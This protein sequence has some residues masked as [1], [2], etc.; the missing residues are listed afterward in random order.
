MNDYKKLQIWQD[1]MELY[2]TV[3]PIFHALRNQRFYRLLDQLEGS[4]GSVADNIAEGQGRNGN[5]E[6]LHFLGIAKGSLQE[7]DS[8]LHRVK[9]LKICDEPTLTEALNKTD[10]LQARIQTLINYL[11]KNSN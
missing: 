4:V 11:K 5:K 10:K 7:C 6:F 1:A 9:L 3:I 2:R 8:Q